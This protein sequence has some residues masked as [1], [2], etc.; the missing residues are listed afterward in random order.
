MMYYLRWKFRYF[1]TL[2]YF[3]RGIHVAYIDICYRTNEASGYDFQ[4]R[5]DGDASWVVAHPGGRTPFHDGMTIVVGKT[6][7]EP[8]ECIFDHCHQSGIVC[9][10]SCLSAGTPVPSSRPQS[11]MQP[12]SALTINELE[13]TSSGRQL[14]VWDDMF[15]HSILTIFC[16]KV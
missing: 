4:V 13:I 3:A 10:A 1:L 7:V 12:L 2:T 9:F 6:R 15:C 16:L 8:S 5:W 14:K 11:S